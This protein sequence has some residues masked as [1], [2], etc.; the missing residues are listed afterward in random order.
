MDDK[1]LD[2]LVRDP[3]MASPA[4]AYAL[5]A[6]ADEVTF[7]PDVAGDVVLLLTERLRPGG[8]LARALPSHPNPCALLTA[9]AKNAALQAI[10]ATGRHKRA[11]HLTDDGDLTA[12]E[13]PGAPIVPTAGIFELLEDLGWTAAHLQALAI[14][15]Q[16]A[17]RSIHPG[18]EAVLDKVAHCYGIT[19]RCPGCPSPMD[20]QRLD[21]NGPRSWP[22]LVQVAGEW[23]WSPD[24]IDY[25]TTTPANIGHWRRLGVTPPPRQERRMVEVVRKMRWEPWLLTDPDTIRNSVK[26]RDPRHGPLAPVPAAGGPAPCRLVDRMRATEGVAPLTG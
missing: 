25:L 19:V 22:A 13:I 15:R 10:E 14:P 12:L 21:L 26:P 2:P 20:L 1:D 24:L 23:G 5:I 3:A 11:M 4:A 8:S 17:G 16:R 18:I 9:A 6:L 7:D